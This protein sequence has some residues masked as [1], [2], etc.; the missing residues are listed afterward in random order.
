MRV[1]VSVRMCVHARASAFVRVTLP[2]A[3]K[4]DWPKESQP[5]FPTLRGLIRVSIT[6]SHFKADHNAVVI[7]LRCILPGHGS[8]L[9]LL[10][11]KCGKCDQ[12]RG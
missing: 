6:P 1:R 3:G 7:A 11:L 4:V 2:R 10:E 8:N 12:C 9:Y 5:V